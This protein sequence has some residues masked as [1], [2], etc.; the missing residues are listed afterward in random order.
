MISAILQ[1]LPESSKKPL[2]WHLV[3]TTIGVLLRALGA[4]VLVPLVAAL[5]S[6][7]PQDACRWLGVLAVVTIAGWIVDWA[8]AQ[9]AFGLGFEL[10]DNGQRSLA[11][12]I[13][14]IRLAWFNAENTST[15]RQA[16]AATGPDLVG[17]IVYF[18]TPLIS[19]ILL[20]LI[21][22]VALLFIAWQLGV[23]AFVGILLLL[24]SFWLSTRLSRNADR[25]AAAGNNRLTERVL[26]FARTQQALRAARRVEPARSHAGAALASLH[27]SMMKNLLMQ[28][29]GQLL[30]SLMSQIAL[31]LLAGTAVYLAVQGTLTA[32]AA[33][34][35]IVVIV[36]YL[37]SFTVFAELSPGVETV[38]TT[39]GN[40][41]QV[42]DAP[43]DPS[44]TKQAETT[45]APEIELR[46]ISFAYPGAQQVLNNFNLRL[47][48]GT[49]TA[50]VG[51]SGSGKTTVLSLIAG[52]YQPQQGQVLVN[53]QDIAQLDADSRRN[54]VCVVFQH[55]Y[56]FDGSIKDNVLTGYPEASKEQLI[57]ASRLARVNTI[58][59]RLPDGWNSRVGEG[60][61]SLSGGERQR[62][63]IARALIKPAP[64][65]LVDEAT[66]ALDPENES[67]VAAALSDDPTPRT[68][69]MIAHR[70]SSIQ[71][72]DRVIFIED[73]RIVEDGSI[74]DLLATDGRFASFW[75]QHSS[76]DNWQLGAQPGAHQVSPSSQD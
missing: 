35:L 22:A 55:P 59:E 5:F 2:T 24:G 32:P 26:E 20:P 9:R 37:E 67:A 72:A 62:I 41:R 6:D 57:D 47:E 52:L 15:T 71:A 27:N 56:L 64:I 3:L 54:L 1:L 43:K 28:I 45:G 66:S 21:I 46:D 11:D 50:I 70:L 8:A 44:G 65:L 69:L 38:T 48:P 36:R 31:F 39:L 53:G 34:A 23:M 61:V 74:P 40:I 75:Q 14:A 4:I 10:L 29:P 76:A 58:L 42:L 49:T 16:V 63:S 30:F 33:I 25:A 51:P 68:R 19:A 13:T 17:V 60:G 7:Q 12:R 18:V 73:G